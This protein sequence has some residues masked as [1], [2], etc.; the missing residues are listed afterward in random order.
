[1]ALSDV[2]GHQKQLEVLRGALKKERL[3]HA[4]LFLGPEG[5]GKKTV[6]LALAMAVQC[7]ELAHDSCGR[8]DGCVRVQRS[9]HP[10]VRLVA[11]LSGRKEITI[12]QV[13]ELERELG[14]RPFYGR[15]RIAIVDPASL[16]NASAQSALLKTLEEPPTDSILILVSPSRGRLLPTLVSRCLRLSFAPLPVAEIQGFL[17]ACKGMERQRAGLVAAISMG[18]LG[19]AV[20]PDVE[21]LVE[22]RRVWLGRMG[23]VTAGDYRG[24]LSMAEELASE[25]EETLKFLEWLV[26]WYRDVLVST[27]TDDPGAVCN[28]DLVEDI[29]RGRRAYR[30]ESVLASLSQASSTAARIQRNVNRR[31]A[32]ENFFMQM[33][34]S[35]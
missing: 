29:Q 28:S 11:P 31:M 8:C 16:M 12:Q 24:A 22:E 7:Q 34:R 26:V 20:S 15:K 23:L 33:V 5:V 18:S 10:D 4:Y 2:V 25:R 21:A 35:L 1:M 17:V 19:K 27:L 30:L 9:N 32:L 14:L 13:R 3:H 6:A